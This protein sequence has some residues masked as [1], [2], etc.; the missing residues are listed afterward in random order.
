MLE[1][2]A[3]VRV[4]IISYGIY[5]GV[6]GFTGYVLTIVVLAAIGFHYLEM[7]FLAYRIWDGLRPT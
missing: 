6:I 2:L 7:P 3:S 1:H 5:H 4:G